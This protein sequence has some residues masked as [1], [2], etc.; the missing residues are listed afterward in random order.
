MDI[1][2]IPNYIVVLEYSKAQIIKIKLSEEDKKLAISYEDSEEMISKLSDK[3]SFGL[4]N[5]EWM[6]LDEIDEVTIGF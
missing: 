1:K 4:S 5:S 6:E 2:D 3:Y